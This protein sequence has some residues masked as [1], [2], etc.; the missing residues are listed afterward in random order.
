MKTSR[1]RRQER[2]PGNSS[3]CSAMW[4][5]ALSFTSAAASLHGECLAYRGNATYQ[6]LPALRNIEHT[7]GRRQIHGRRRRRYFVPAG[8]SGPSTF[9]ASTMVRAAPDCRRARCACVGAGGAAAFELKAAVPASAQ[10]LIR[11]ACD[12][13]A[14][15]AVGFSQ[16]KSA[17]ALARSEV[18]GAWWPMSPRGRAA[19]LVF[20]VDASLPRRRD[21][22]GD[23]SARV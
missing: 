15:S 7:G 14:H 21:A 13:R 12:D 20:S 5:V 11:M 9:T 22:G 23:L 4:H 10:R 3:P 18:S 2:R 1:R 16:A 17:P 8:A 19:P 6:A